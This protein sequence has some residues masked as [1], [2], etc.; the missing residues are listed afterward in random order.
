MS[1]EYHRQRHLSLFH[2]TAHPGISN[3]AATGNR[4]ADF[5]NSVAS[6]STATVAANASC[7]VS[8]TFSPIYSGPHSETLAV[9]DDAPNS[10]QVLSIFA[11]APPAFSISSPSSALAASVSAGQPA[12]YTLQLI[13]GLDYNGTISFSFTYTGAPLGATCQAPSTVVLNTGA[14][15]AFTVTV[16][17][18]GSAIVAP[19]FTS[20]R[21]PQPPTAPGVFTG[22]LS[23]LFLILVLLLY[24]EWSGLPGSPPRH[25]GGES[26]MPW[27]H[28]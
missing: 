14:P 25:R 3:I 15:A 26:L 10:P 28:C 11:S 17:T 18:S 23:M 27:Q 20:R 19:K 12:S 24:R 6:C 21:V 13:P 2:S 4:P 16:T 5:T 9:T 7:T 22:A 8:V 1:P